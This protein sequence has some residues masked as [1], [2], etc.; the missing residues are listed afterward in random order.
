MNDKFLLMIEAVLNQKD[1]KSDYNEM[2]K[3]LEKNPT[4]INAIM[5]TSATKTEINK[6]IKEIAP[7]LQKMFSSKGVEVDLKDIESAMKSV[8]KESEKAA[9]QLQ[10]ETEKMHRDELK[11]YTHNE[12][13]KQ[14]AIKQTAKVSQDALS[15]DARKLNTKSNID[16]FLARNT[17][18]TKETRAE[19]LKLK[20]AIDSV[21]D[22]KSLSNINEEL[23][24]LKN[25]AKATGQIGMSMGDNFKEAFGKFSVW[26]SASAIFFGVQRVI[27]NI[28]GEVKNIDSSMINLKKVTS[29]TDAT[30]DRFLTNASQKAK[31]LGASISDLINATAD[32][33]RLG[34]NLPDSAKLGE[35]AT[36]YKNVGDGIDIG[37][38]TSSI[39]S[40]LKAFNIEAENSISI[41]DK[42]NEVGNNFAI[43]SVGIGEALQRSASAL[44]SANNT[45]DESIALITAGN[46]V[47]QDPNM[48]GT[49]L[50]TVSLRLRST[51]TEIEN[52]GEDAEGAVE[53]VSDLR[54]LL[55]ALTNQKV[56]IQLDEDTYKSTYQI[57][58]EMS[59]V[60]DS[61]TDMSQASALESMFGK[62]Q[63]NIGASILQN[64]SEAEDVLKTSIESTGSALREQE[65]Y[66]EGI[67]YSLDRLKASMQEL[68]LK[69][70]DSSAIKF[71]VDL[72]N[73]AVNATT[74]VGGLVPVLSTLAVLYLSFNKNEKYAFLQNFISY[75]FK[76]K[77]TADATAVSIG[78]LT[79]SVKALTGIVTGG[80]LIAIPLIAKG[81]DDIITTLEEQKEALEASNTA[82]EESKTKLESINSELKTTEERISALEA[83]D[84]LT[85][86]E[87]GELQKLKDITAELL[88][89]QDIQQRKK[90][91]DAKALAV[92]ASDT[93]K[94]QF[95][96]NQ[97][98]F[99][100]PEQ[101]ITDEQSMFDIRGVSYED[102]SS[103]YK[104]IAAYKEFNELKSE[105]L[106]KE[107]LYGDDSQKELDYYAK[108][109]EGVNV[110]LTSNLDDLKLQKA[111]M[112][113]YYDVIKNTPYD[114]LNSEQ[115]AI[116]DNYNAISSII[117]LIY[118]NIDPAKWKEIQFTEVFNSSEMKTVKKQ[119]EELAK[120]GTLK[121]S[122]LTSNAEYRKLLDETGLSASDVV[123]QINA[124]V[125]VTSNSDADISEVLGLS[126]T[127]TDL[128]KLS[129]SMN[130]LDSAYAK[131]S[132]KEKLDISDLTSLQRQFG[133]TEGFDD[134]INIVSTAG[135]VTVDVQ[136]AFEELASTYISTS[137]ILDTLTDENKNLVIAQLE[138][139]GVSNAEEIVT[140]KLADNKQLLI[141]TGIDLINTTSDEIIAL[142]NEKETS[143]ETRLALFDLAKEKI[144]VNDVAISTSGDIQNLLELMKVANASTKS[145][146]ILER[147]RS[148]EKIPGVTP[149]YIKRIMEGAQSEVDAFYADIQNKQ[150][151]NNASKYKATYTGGDKTKS[152]LDKK[153][154]KKDKTDPIKDAFD[155]G[156]KDKKGN[157]IVEGKNDLDHK[158]AM[159]DITIKQYYDGLEKI[160]K[161]TYGKNKK[162]HLENYRQYVEEV[163]KGRKKIDEEF[164]KSKFDDLSHSFAM[165]D[166]KTEESYQ[167]QRWELAKDYYK[168]NKDYLDEWKKAQEDWYKWNLEQTEKSV[169]DEQ[170]K[171]LNTIDK[172]IDKYGEL[173][174]TI[175]KTAENQTGDAQVSTYSE[176]I[177]YA[178]KEIKYIE[179][180]I[181]K[182]NKR[183]ITNLF[184]QDDYDSQLANLQSAL[185]KARSSIDN[186]NKSISE[187]IKKSSEETMDIIEKSF[188]KTTEYWEN[189]KKDYSDI[190][191]AQ[192]DILQLKKEQNEYEKSI[193][194]KT[195]E[196]SKIESRM[197]DLSKAAM[198]GDRQ[199]NAEL[200]KL[201]EDLADK[202][203]DLSDTQS[204]HEYDLANDA[205]DKALDDNDK[206]IDA[207]LKAIKTEYEERKTI[208]EDLFKQLETLTTNAKNF[209][210]AEYSAAIDEIAAK[211]A[212]SGIMLDD[213]TIGGLKGAQGQP[214]N[215]ANPVYSILGNKSN[216]NM[217]QDTSSLSGLNKFLASQGYSIANKGKMVELAQALGLYNITSPEMVGT[218]QLGRANKNLIMEELK[219]LF[220]GS[221]FSK[222]GIAKLPKMMGEDGFALIKNEEPVLTVE[223]GKLFKELVNNIKPLNNLVKLSTPNLSGI[224]NNNNS[225]NINI[226]ITIQG[227]ATPSTV[228]ALNNAGNNIVKQ[229]MDEVR[230]L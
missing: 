44:A 203:E 111:D 107:N 46:N 216:S 2:K 51:A 194:K 193:A 12:K 198:T 179:N 145:L 176:G 8:F 17:K 99:A 137:G 183:K 88:I 100:T 104:L 126:D 56:D 9:K 170:K 201:E 66:Q 18:M 184:T 89:Q 79:L 152:A 86:V 204:D 78:G 189:Q 208:Q 72:A 168:N 91:E 207:K 213:T 98:N 43:S 42:F 173:R 180:E 132:T 200:K 124:I 27:K 68:S 197:A 94:M 130:A 30:Y 153:K 217:S 34:Y 157:I 95:G 39:I 105:A 1:I 161:A 60:W 11:A 185:S 159:E 196:I 187:S 154:P 33:A 139:M 150:S 81:L 106:Q 64:M 25:N 53:N 47:V 147:L 82:Y 84:N 226:P 155:L 37:G 120:A 169:A 202:K 219:R 117:E 50:K 76:T 58:L 119:L 13:L 26:V 70:L 220:S 62:R 125:D 108:S 74:A 103:I 20:A 32:F 181:K 141:D 227:N 172:I 230:K 191:K 16:A 123:S 67:Q 214:Y 114:E 35:I 127:I 112:Q 167:K 221:T 36:L 151:T 199:A 45:L 143:E 15:L 205:L 65:K 215:N 75:L 116:Y 7:Q 182:L 6:F 164:I 190:I 4:K 131:L 49:A 192:K 206:I 122:V 24:T 160:N 92:A 178:N 21:D 171:R 87:D 223:Q 188:N 156:I 140:K 158:L 142:I 29:E 209:T 22:S 136:S 210:I 28:V 109:L 121:E 224:T 61:M 85:F 148:G 229:I 96:N 55:L 144:G 134:F 133:K 77:L 83:K 186:F 128:D 73:G 146:E 57:M 71:F 228:S 218:D 225:P 177:K 222:G 54:D 93:F 97:W 165:G 38:A 90:D 52:L 110:L 3:W 19:F 23:G 5:D 166:I 10:K 212:Q 101:Q 162:T 59:K 211:F 149:D 102:E 163:S 40:T 41:V 129:D 138:L 113:D 48:V 63:A 135:S 195:K 80:L 69:T 118:T 175:N 14:D 31:E 174:D 115:K